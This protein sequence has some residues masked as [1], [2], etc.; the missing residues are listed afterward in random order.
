MS[1]IVVVA[2]LE[3]SSKMV[4]IVNGVGIDGIMVNETMIFKHMKNI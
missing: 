3:E 1:M 4:G 2:E